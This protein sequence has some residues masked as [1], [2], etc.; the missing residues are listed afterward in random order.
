MEKDDALMVVKLE[1]PSNV[2]I[3]MEVRFGG[4]FTDVK[5]EHPWKM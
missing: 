4:K 5:D 3:E 2:L 1:H